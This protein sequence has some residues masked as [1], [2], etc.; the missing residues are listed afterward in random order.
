MRALLEMPAPAETASMR[1][2]SPRLDGLLEHAGLESCWGRKWAYCWSWDR[3]LSL[4]SLLVVVVTVLVYRCC[5][6][7]WQ[8]ELLLPYHLPLPLPPSGLLS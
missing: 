3:A 2:A 7:C 8:A 5:C 4:D 1:A 6:C